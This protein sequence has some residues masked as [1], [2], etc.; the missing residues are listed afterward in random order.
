MGGLV[1]VGDVE[2]ELQVASTDVAD[3]D[4]IS[5]LISTAFDHFLY[6]GESLL[7]PA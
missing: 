6:L 1:L 5:E 3:C 7:H 2:G 4:G